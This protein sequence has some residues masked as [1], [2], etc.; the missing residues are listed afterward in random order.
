MSRPGWDE[1]GMAIAV[2]VATRGD[3][4]RRQVGAVILSERHDVISIGYNGTAPGR[5]GCLDGGCP[6]GQFSLEAIPDGGD[7]DTPGTDSY[8]IATHAEMNALV[9]ADH[10]RLRG[11]TMYI[12]LSPCN[13]CTKIISNTPLHKIIWLH[14]DGNLITKLI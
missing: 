1:W 6:R 4:T 10:E 11:A 14:P 3:C 13:G 5:L 8:C 9:R 7:Y 12:T 2:A